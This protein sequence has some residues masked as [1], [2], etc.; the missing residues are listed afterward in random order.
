MLDGA[1]ALVIRGEVARARLEIGT[2]PSK[3]VGA[4]SGTGYRSLFAGSDRLHKPKS[5]E[6]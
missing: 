6:Q 1:A 2:Q 5:L 4:S 3:G